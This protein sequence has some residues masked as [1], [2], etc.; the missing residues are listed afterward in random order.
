M[1]ES[2]L[3]HN[4]KYNDK[5][6][7]FAGYPVAALSFIFFANDNP[8]SKLILLPTFFSDVFFAVIVTF[9]VGFYIRKITL[10]LDKYHPWHAGFKKRL[11]RQALLGI[12]VPL[13]VSMLCEAIY[14][15]FINIPIRDS[16]IFNLELPLAFVFLIGVNLFYL[17]NYLFY[18]KNERV[19]IITEPAAIPDNNS[20]QYI[21]VQKGFVEEKVPVEDCAIIIS[22]NKILWL[23]SYNGEQYRLQGTLE[24]WEEKL[25]DVNFYRINR[26]YLAAFHAIKSVEQT[27]TRKLKVNF[28]IPTEAVYVSKLN[29]ASFR[30]WWKNDSPS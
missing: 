8:L 6:L 7:W 22:S 17:T 23:H 20:I 18:Q 14:L 30:Q 27:S 4:K 9:L 29:A 25:K 11:L 2:K 10:R 19:I 5:L 21:T 13:L 28:V 26:Q 1:P 16:S 15:Y 3:Y 12:L 24:E